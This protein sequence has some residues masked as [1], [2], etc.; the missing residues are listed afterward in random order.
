MKKYRYI[1]VDLF[2]KKHSGYYLAENKRDLRCRLAEQNLYLVRAKRCENRTSFG[3]TI[4]SGEL[5]FFCRQFSVM[6]S[7]GVSVVNTLSVLK[8]A[9][10]GCLKK[11]LEMVYGDVNGG[12][13]LSVAFGKHVKMLPRLMIG[14]IRI[15]EQSGQIGAAFASV[16]DY[17]EADAKAKA[18]TQAALAYP[19]L[20]VILILALFI[21]T[22]SLI[23]PVFETALSSLDVERPAITV[24]LFALAQG[25]HKSWKIILITAAALIAVFLVWIH[26]K[27]GRYVWDKGKYCLKLMKNSTSARFCRAFSLLL[28]GGM[29]V[30]ESLEET[31]SVLGN[32]FVLKRLKR[33]ADRVRQGMTLAAALQE[34][35]LFSDM[36]IRMIAAGESAGELRHILDRAS[37]YFDGQVQRTVTVFTGMI[38]PVMII[39]IGAMVGILF[40]ALY[41][42]MLQVMNGLDIRSF[43]GSVL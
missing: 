25:F 38:Q 26:T 29:D 27:K 9:H 40:Y 3:R 16:A 36:L 32:A 12:T 42:P 39:I 17:L 11:V 10:A 24:G 20:L 1:A 18:K 14:M 2:G 35:R 41:A 28:V 33:A 15:G 23:I 43:I 4:S 37:L 8:D 19:I 31:A 5:S 7:S 6:V 13:L 21:L 30:A 22:V 34:S